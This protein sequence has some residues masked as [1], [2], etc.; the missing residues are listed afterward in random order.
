MAAMR[1][2]QGIRAAAAACALAL[3]AVVVAGSPAPAAPK[4]EP[5]KAGK[6]LLQKKPNVIV[7]MTDDQDNSLVGMSNVIS[8][9]SALGTTFANSYTSYP[10]C[11][12]SR[13]TFLTGQFAH[14]HHVLK[15]DN[16]EAYNSLNHKNTLPL[17]LRRDGYETAMIGKYLNGYGMNDRRRE[18]VPDIREIPPGWT[19][20][21]ALTG[22]SAQRRYEY[23]LNENGKVRF[24]GKGAKNYVTDVL[25]GK[26]VRYINEKAPS[27][28]PFFLWFTPTAPHGESGNLLGRSRNP[29]PAKRHIGRYGDAI[30]PR[31]PNFDEADVSD[32]PEFIRDTPRLTE[33]QINDVDARYRG[34][35]ESLL[36]VDEA[37]KRIIG[38]VRRSGDMRKTFI[39]FTS[40]NGMQLG[41]HRLLFKAYLY[42]ESARVPLIVRGPGFP[43]GTVREQLVSNVDL[44]P[45][46]VE[47]TGARPRLAMD[48]RSLVPIAADPT[49]GTDRALLLESPQTASFGIREGDY[50]YIT[51][52]DTGEN[53]LYDLAED[54]F[55]LESLHDVPALNALQ[56]SLAAKLGAARVC[57]GSACP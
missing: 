21:F 56:F 46:I 39:V 51:H 22:K 27:S 36:S 33:A 11:C 16:A 7:V 55:Q 32:K 6:N 14:N 50:V 20:W 2:R 28:R 57:G 5:S 45:T 34:R 42:E 43:A 12:P 26:A 25:A 10:L 3:I 29:T 19:D 30:Y 17:W 52:D 15:S 23:K 35:I 53:E 48:G 31:T 24:Y 54:P 13:A 44:A 8:Q 1:A 49:S 41:S 38:A 40:D 4:A 37:V 9:M 18:K 47:L